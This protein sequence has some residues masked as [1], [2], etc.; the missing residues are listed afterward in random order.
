M[1]AVLLYGR[2]S[3]SFLVHYS[4][5]LRDMVAQ[6]ITHQTLVPQ[7]GLLAWFPDQT[8]ICWDL[9][10][11]T[12]LSL[13]ISIQ[14]YLI[15]NDL[16]QQNDLSVKYANCCL[17]LYIIGGRIFQCAFCGCFLCSDDQFEHQA[18][19]QVLE[20]ETYKCKYLNLT[21]L[22]FYL[23]WLMLVITKVQA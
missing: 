11:D 4:E 10:Q 15:N 1:I 13:S 9:V 19:C 5:P 12:S 22:L 8:N 3:C 7:P 14:V 17:W 23:L 18:K 16:Y 20:S 21:Y 6:W 2:L